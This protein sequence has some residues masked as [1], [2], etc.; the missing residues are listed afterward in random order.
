MQRGRGARQQIDLWQQPL[1][2]PFTPPPVSF[3]LFFLLGFF[4]AA[5][6]KIDFLMFPPRIPFSLS[7]FSFLLLP[8]SLAISFK[9]VTFDVK[10]RRPESSQPLTHK[11]THAHRGLDVEGKVRPALRGP[12]HPLSLSGLLTQSHLIGRVCACEKCD[13]GCNSVGVCGRVCEGWIEPGERCVKVCLSE[14]V[15]SWHVNVRLADDRFGSDDTQTHTHMQTHTH[16]P[17]ARTCGVISGL[18]RGTV[19]L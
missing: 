15:H 19:G 12:N 9:S 8:V 13:H 5:Y 3:W 18:I 2:P 11:N 1:S 6:C 7:V 10:W 4:L 17:L 14:S 16:N